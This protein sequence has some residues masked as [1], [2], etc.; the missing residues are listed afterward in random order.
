MIED[1]IATKQQLEKE[2]RVALATM[3]K[4]ESI[5]QIRSK[6]RVNQSRCPHFDA[7]Y[8]YVWVDDTCPYC[9]KRHCK[10]PKEE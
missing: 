1:I 9:G 10:N 3:E 8:N 7:K 2:L 5:F 4:S 6:M